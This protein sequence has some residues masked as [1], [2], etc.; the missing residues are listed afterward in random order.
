MEIYKINHIYLNQNK[1]QFC[2]CTNKGISTFSAQN[3]S[4]LNSS[5]TNEIILGEIS[6]A[7]LLYELNIVVFVGSE[8]NDEYNNK[9]LVFYDLVNK[10]EIYSTFFISPIIDIKSILK[11]VF[12]I[13]NKELIVY[14]YANLNEINLISSIPFL[15]ENN[16][17]NVIWNKKEND[18][19]NEELYIAMYEKKEKDISV[20]S[21]FS[22]NY[23][24]KKNTKTINSPFSKIQNMFYIEEL[25]QLFLVDGTG[26]YISSFDI[27]TNKLIYNLYRGN[28]PGEIISMCKLSKNHLAVINKNKTIHIFDLKDSNGYNI[29]NILYKM[30][31]SIIYSTMKIRLKDVFKEF[32]NSFFNLYYNKYGC[33]IY[34]LGNSNQ[35]YV[36]GYN[37]VGLIIKINFLK[38]DYVIVNQTRFFQ[39]NSLTMG[40]SIDINEN[41][42]V[43][44]SIYESKNIESNKWDI[45]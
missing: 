20:I 18:D 2:V 17:G 14:S 25:D 36:I 15:N 41:D 6:K 5:N 11:Y 39:K 1:T 44:S 42:V 33:F 45:I 22:K 8:N 13:S 34:N 31:S 12:V 40:Q 24:Y 37:G 43:I 35:I 26:C 29:K 16:L 10:K 38:N 28:K 7:N 4:P 21:Y 27:E 23:F 19:L 30:M 9:K 32:E 3:F